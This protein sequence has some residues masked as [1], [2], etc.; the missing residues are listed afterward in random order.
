[1]AD[2]SAWVA[3]AAARRW[4]GVLLAL[5]AFATDWLTGWHGMSF[6]M[7]GLLDW[8]AHLATALVILG[9]V[10]RVRE[11]IP[12]QRF[13]WTMLACAVLIDL[14][15][16][17]KRE[18]GSC[19]CWTNG[20][21]RPYTHALWSVIVLALAWAVARFFVIRAGRPR[22]LTVEL[23]LAGA[24]TGVAAHFVRDIATAPM[25]FWW[26]VTDMAVEVP[27][28]W[29]VMALAVLIAI[30][31]IRQDSRPTGAAAMGVTHDRVYDDSP[32][33]KVANSSSHVTLREQGGPV[34]GD[35][36]RHHRHW[37]RSMS[38]ILRSPHLDRLDGHGAV[39]RAQ[40]WRLYRL[41]S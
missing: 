2:C 37:S 35:A 13:G 4:V 22:P 34:R 6:A 36:N 21:P 41:H 7:R 18:F 30:G 23:I 29:Y 9:A 10:I 38:A 15:H 8:P 20:T 19:R 1:M 31:P 33:G 32:L 3:A 24:A 14:D 26:P 12:D 39:A 5:Y 25:S 16:V 27:Y 11:T 40:Q 28:W 17:P